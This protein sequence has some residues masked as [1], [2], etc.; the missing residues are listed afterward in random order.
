MSDV[1]TTVF[2]YNYSSNMQDPKQTPDIFILFIKV[3]V[4][5]EVVKFL[6]VASK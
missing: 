6:H 5:G 1:N 3:E 2:T 4:D